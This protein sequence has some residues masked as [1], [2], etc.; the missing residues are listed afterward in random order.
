[1]DTAGSRKTE[2][3]PRNRWAFSLSAKTAFLAV[4][5]ILVPVFLY[6]EFRRAYEESQELLGSVRA[7]GRTINQS[8]LPLLETADNA[9]LP[10]LGSHLTWLAFVGSMP[11]H[12]FASGIALEDR[13]EFARPF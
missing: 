11:P 12:L 6:L 10:E 1:L 3:R 9:T 4:V 13:S 5:F 7:G 8:L 2:T